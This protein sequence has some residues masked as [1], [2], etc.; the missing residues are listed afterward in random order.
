SE[1]FGTEHRYAMVLHT[2]QRHPHVHLVVKAEGLRG[3]RLHID[4]QL[5]REWRG[6]FARYMREQGVAANA[7]KR[8]IR[9][10]AGSKNSDALLRAQRRNGSSATR[11]RV[12]TV[13]REL[14]SGALIHDP[15]R[16]KLLKTR[17]AV[18]AGWLAV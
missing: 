14:A 9:G 10:R 8:F 7:T 13:A 16:E 3:R 12:Q 11:E 4:K 6:D 15:A 2:D 18:V 5:L 17:T 1:K